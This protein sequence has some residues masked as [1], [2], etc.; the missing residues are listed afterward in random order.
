MNEDIQPKEITKCKDTHLEI[1]SFP[2]YDGMK[3]LKNNMKLGL[4]PTTEFSDVRKDIHYIV[5]CGDVMIKVSTSN[6][7]NITRREF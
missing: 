3:F 6:Y 2:Y 7:P 5:C 1:A 4:K